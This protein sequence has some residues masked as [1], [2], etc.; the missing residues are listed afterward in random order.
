MSDAQTTLEVLTDQLNEASIG[1]IAAF[2]KFGVALEDAAHNMT[3]QFNALPPEFYHQMGM[4]HPR[5][6]LDRHYREVAEPDEVVQYILQ[7]PNHTWM[8]VTIWPDEAW[9]YSDKRDWMWWRE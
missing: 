9:R 8:G 3:V 5:E 7:Q 2:S 1:I 4:L 6:S